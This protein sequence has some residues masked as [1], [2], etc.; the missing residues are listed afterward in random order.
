MPV[1]TQCVLALALFVGVDSFA[2]LPAELTVTTV[3]G[4]IPDFGG[5]NVVCDH[6]DKA[7]PKLY[8]DVDA[9]AWANLST[10]MDGFE[11]SILA[12]PVCIWR[13]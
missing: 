3:S 13:R 10:A 2:N 4:S 6:S 7:A 12:P 1:V 9:A 5:V 8:L 11:A